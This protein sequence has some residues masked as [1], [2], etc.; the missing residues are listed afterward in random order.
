MRIMLF[1]AGGDIGGGKTHILSLA[2]ELAK[3]NDL[4]LVSFRKGVL[5]EEGMEMGIDTVDTGG[6][7]GILHSIRLAF[8][9]AKDFRPDVIHCHGAKGNM[10]GILVKWFLHVP[11]M[12]TVHSDPDL[13][14]L[15]APVRNALNGN[16]NKFCLRRMDY[17]VAVA[18]RMRELLIQRGFDAQNIF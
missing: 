3:D 12:T 1:A 17:H 15:G 8:R 10:M 4:R 9:Q 14:Y 2:K 5:S 11:V 13:D 6:N 18:D 16:I 7:N